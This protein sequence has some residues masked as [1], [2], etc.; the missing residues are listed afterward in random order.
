MHQEPTVDSSAARTIAVDAYLFFY[1]LVTMDLTR[2]QAIAAGGQRLLG[3]G[4]SNVFTHVPVYPPVGFRGVVRPNFDTLY[5]VAWL[6]LAR[7]PMVLSVPDTAGRYYLLQLLDLW[8]DTV[9]A[10]GSRSTG[11]GAGT[12]LI[13]AP[14]WPPRISQALGLPPETRLIV[15]TTPCAWLLGRLKTDGPPDYAAVRALQAG[16][17]LTPLS[18][19]GGPPPAADPQP[20]PGLDRATPP[21]RQVDGMAAEP[22]FA[23]AAELLKTTPA[24]ATDQPMLD[25]LRKLGIVPGCGL[26]LEAQPP[27]VRAALH[28]A[29][30]AAQALMRRAAG[31]L[32]RLVNGWSLI[33][34]TIGVYGNA[35][36]RRAVIAQ[37]GLGANP[38]E[39]AVYPSASVDSEGR[40]LDGRFRYRLHVAAGAEPPVAAFWS[41]TLYDLEGFPT[42]NPLDRYALSSWM[43]LRRNPDGSLDLFLQGDSPGPDRE[44][45]WLPAPAAPFTLTMRLYDPRPEI[46]YGDWVPPPVVRQ[47]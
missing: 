45:N 14:G 2:R 3:R 24:H 22:F 18:H 17:T 32:G 35:Y 9:A 20:D 31:T 1:P 23:Y 26:D 28:D 15:A 27:A 44:A 36:L 25:Q 19:W 30:A 8:T 39:D 40:P 43:P 42:A 37:R 12:F 29:P 13:V 34:D 11:T 7:E 10:P 6:D 33:T 47:D 16:L 5:S 46:L 38:P 21:K 41:I 4:G